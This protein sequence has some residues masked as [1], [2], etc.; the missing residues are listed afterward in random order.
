MS[1]RSIIILGSTGSIGRSALR[2]IRS[3]PERFAV[4]G[5]SCSSSLEELRGQIR[6]F[7]PEYAAVTG[8]C[9]VA[10]LAAEFPG[11]KFLH[12]A[13]ALDELV[14]VGCDILLT[15]VVGAAGLA[16]TI[17]AMPHIRTLA[18]ANKETLV[19][20]GDIVKAEAARHGV[21][22]IPVD[23]EHSAIFQ[24]LSPEHRRDLHRII[25]TASGGSMRDRTLDQMRTITPA[26]ALQHP[27]WNMG[28]KITID[29][30]TLMNK[31][32]EVIEAHHLF[33]LKYD[34]IDVVVHPES[35]IH[36]MIETKD[37]SVYSHMGVTDMVYP[38]MNAF[39]Y[40]ERLETPFPR[41]DFSRLKSLTFRE[42]DPVRFP[43]LKLCYE[44]GRTGGSA[45][46][47]LNGANEVAV[48][49]FLEGRIPFT[50][51]VEI[52]KRVLDTIPAASRPVLAE[53]READR[54][55]RECAEKIIRSNQ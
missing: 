47:I 6:E 54:K 16:P 33:D 40:P 38:I 18:I 12:G 48:A 34:M 42:Y 4:R 3:F 15:S 37:G 45:P 52:V 28:S 51:I 46:C 53:L 13:N 22:I 19:V 26:E 8:D 50:G 31:G 20:G 7:N 25:I 23:S 2:V 27:T 29:S 32:L 41:L 9:S 55:S 43:G 30:A 24:L 39:S 17:A 35:V 5:L 10:A 44:A 49:A 1:S 21:Q 11:T 36:S 14:T